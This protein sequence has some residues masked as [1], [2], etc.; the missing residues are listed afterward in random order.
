MLGWPSTINSTPPARLDPREFTLQNLRR[1]SDLTQE[2]D[3][4]DFGLE[5]IFSITASGY[6]RGDR[7]VGIAPGWWAAAECI[8]A[9]LTDRGEVALT[10]EQVLDLIGADHVAEAERRAAEEYADGMEE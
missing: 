2:V 3:T 4:C 10:R 8:G 6:D 9:V 5:L 7:D 1:W